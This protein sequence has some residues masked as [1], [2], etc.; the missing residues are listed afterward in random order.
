[1]LIATA[2]VTLPLTA[3]L[4]VTALGKLG[5]RP[6]VVATYTRVGV[7][8]DRLNL[9]AG[10]AGLVVGLFL[11]PV[12][13]A[14]AAALVVYFALAIAAHLRA[15]DAANTPMP[16]LYLLLAAAVPTLHAL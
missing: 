2:A 9:L 7:P 1:M 13:I 14:A 3:L 6:D 16:A 4:P 11:T 12:G 15:R 10:A 8:E 5:H